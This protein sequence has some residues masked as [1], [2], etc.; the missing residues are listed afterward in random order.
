M[1]SDGLVIKLS[2]FFLLILRIMV[3]LLVRRLVHANLGPK[4]IQIMKWTNP[5]A[6]HTILSPFPVWFLH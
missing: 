5:L 1:R 4:L 2:R 6:F 3:I